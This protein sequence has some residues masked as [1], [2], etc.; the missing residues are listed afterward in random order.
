M[1]EAEAEA[2]ARYDKADLTWSHPSVEA[3]Q[4]LTSWRAPRTF[5]RLVVPWIPVNVI[6]CA[7]DLVIGPRSKT[8]RYA[9]LPIYHGQLSSG[10]QSHSLAALS[11]SDR[12]EVA[13]GGAASQRRT[14][15]R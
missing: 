9:G 3:G 7:T 14:A 6:L 11:L 4:T 2:V 13:A 5:F 15:W 1:A 12:V 8:L 10:A